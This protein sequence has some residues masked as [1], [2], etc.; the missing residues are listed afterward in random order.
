MAQGFVSRVYLII[1][2]SSLCGK[3]SV[4]SD[5]IRS[6]CI[7]VFVICDS[8]AVVV[9]IFVLYD[10]AEE[11]VKVGFKSFIF[12]AGPLRSGVPAAFKEAC[13]LGEYVICYVVEV[14]DGFCPKLALDAQEIAFA[15]S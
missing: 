1:P 8:Y 4:K 11:L 9:R 13:G 10:D 3:D 5:I 7:L 15:L 2:L 14:A 6:L 12:C